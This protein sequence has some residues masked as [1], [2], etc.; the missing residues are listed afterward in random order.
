[1][2]T[3]VGIPSS[4]MRW[5]NTS[6]WRGVAEAERAARADGRRPMPKSTVSPLGTQRHA[7]VA[8]PRARRHAA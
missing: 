1:M 6:S 3:I 2:L 8:D 4:E 7:D 5:S